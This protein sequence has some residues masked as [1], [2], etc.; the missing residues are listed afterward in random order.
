MHAFARAQSRRPS[1]PAAL[2]RK[3][4]AGE[5][6]RRRRRCGRRNSRNRCRNRCRTPRQSPSSAMRR[7][8][9]TNPGSPRARHGRADLALRLRPAHLR[10]AES[11]AGRCAPLARRRCAYT[12]KGNKTRLVPLLPIVLEAVEKYRALP[13]IIS[14]R[15]LPL[16]RGARGGQAAGRHHPARHAEAAQR[17]RPAGHRR[18]AACA[19]P[20][21]FFRHASARRWW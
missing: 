11:D 4:G 2:P 8:C 14:T 10:S 20:F 3:E 5:C 18:Y 16:F 12:G 15:A 19:A 21:P 1:F 17:L 6:G 9:M 7:R 13:P